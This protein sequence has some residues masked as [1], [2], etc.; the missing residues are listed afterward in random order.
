MRLW[1]CDYVHL[2]PSLVDLMKDREEEEGKGNW[3][4]E[5]KNEVCF[6][7]FAGCSW[8]PSIYLLVFV[9]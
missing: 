9:F 1:D 4:I 8:T 2:S 7:T 6:W 5:G 3:G